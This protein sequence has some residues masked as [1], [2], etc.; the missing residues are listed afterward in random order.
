MK[1]E[2]ASKIKNSPEKR[3]Y[4]DAC[5]AAH[6]LD[7]VGERWALPVM[8][9]LMFG[10]KRFTDLRRD[11]PAISANVLTQRLEGLEAAGVLIRRKLPPPAAAWVYELTAWG[12]AS[13]PIFKVLGRW[14]AMSPFHDPSQ[15]ISA[16]S[17]LLSF[18]T[19]IDPEKA[20]GI[21]ARIGFQFR[22][23]SFVGEIDDGDIRISRGEVSAVDV[24]FRGA[25]DALIAAVYGKTPLDAL[26]VDGA[27]AV[28]GD[29]ALA[30]RF[31]GLFSLP[32]KAALV[33]A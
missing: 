21:S 19:M 31:V 18:R 11:L 4:A 25:P 29:R 1:I 17:V 27:L 6:A 10:P 30:D 14:G 7:L 24:C 5:A 20:R 2:K 8:R 33:A 3:Q 26:A 9:E 23:E 15:P 12:Y 28:T 32:E 13:E 16:N 22:E